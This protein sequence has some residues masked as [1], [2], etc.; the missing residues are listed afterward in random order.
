MELTARDRIEK[1]I[2][3]KGLIKAWDEL[4][5]KTDYI[6]GLIIIK[7]FEDCDNYSSLSQDDYFK[8][9]KYNEKSLSVT[10]ARTLAKATKE[11]VELK[12][13]LSNPSYSTSNFL[14]ETEAELSLPKSSVT[15]ISLRGDNA[16]E[17]AR[18]WKDIQEAT[19]K[20][21]PTD[22]E[23]R[24]HNKD[25]REAKEKLESIQKKKDDTLNEYAKD[26]QIPK[27][28]PKPEP[29]TIDEEVDFETWCIK[30]HNF[31]LVAERPKHTR[32]IYA[33]KDEKV[34]TLFGRL[35]EWKSAFR[36]MAKLCH[37]ETGGNTLAMSILNDFNELMKS[38]GGVKDVIDYEK[39]I[40]ELR[41][42]Y[43]TPKLK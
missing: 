2:D 36:I 41:V 32:A 4:S 43:S 34:G 39:R 9:F 19:G 18:N 21:E 23:V 1:G 3:R 28:L 35:D 24:Q 8:G 13:T 20:E 12:K 42:E 10:Y 31:D 5:D 16:I 15:Q 40:E 37:P 30:E 38:L 27:K 11:K 22:R 29:F 6:R 25:I 14:K 7:A 26:R 17:K 33:L